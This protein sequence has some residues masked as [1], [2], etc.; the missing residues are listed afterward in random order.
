MYF[1][2]FEI[3]LFCFPIHQLTL[4]FLNKPER[5]IFIEKKIN[6]ETVKKIESEVREIK[7]DEIKFNDIKNV[8]IEMQKQ[9]EIIKTDIKEIK[10]NLEIK[11]KKTNQI[12][13]D[14]QM[15][16]SEYDDADVIWLYEKN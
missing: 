16:S 4:I 7:V 1:I 15:I 11:N 5:L 10:K 13:F 2:F 8:R 3:I 9:N 12:I 14:S 6:M